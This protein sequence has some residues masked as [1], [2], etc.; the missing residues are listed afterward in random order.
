MK[1]GEARRGRGRQH[2]P[3]NR[4]IGRERDEERERKGLTKGGKRTWMLGSLGNPHEPLEVHPRYTLIAF[5]ILVIPM[6]LSPSRYADN[7][8]R[9]SRLRFESVIFGEIDKILA[10]RIIRSATS[11]S[12]RENAEISSMCLTSLKNNRLT[13]DFLSNGNKMIRVK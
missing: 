5:P 6:H 4:G 13:P 7:R 9:L 1:E 8:Y 3:V 11:S 10:R 12:H 2:E